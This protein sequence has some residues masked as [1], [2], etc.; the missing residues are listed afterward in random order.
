M[1]K[2][3]LPINVAGLLAAALVCSTAYAEKYPIMEKVADKIVHK[4]ETSSCEELKE[5]RG[6]PKSEKKE[7]ME[8]RVVK[9]LREDA[10]M[11][12]AFLNKVAAPIA[13]KLLEC[14][15]IP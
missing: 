13:N 10:G 15:L 9:L 4:Y 7:E 2:I 3:V 14:G 11:R 1:L 8:E 5:E 6:K 12:K